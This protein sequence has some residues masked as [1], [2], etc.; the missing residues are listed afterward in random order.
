LLRFINPI[1]L[2]RGID[3]IAFNARHPRA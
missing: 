2:K 1:G 3:A